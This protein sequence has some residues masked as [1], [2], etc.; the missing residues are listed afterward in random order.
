MSI[1]FDFS[2]LINGLITSF[3]M[4][5][6]SLRFLKINIFKTKISS[7]F[8]LLVL[9]ICIIL[10]YLITNFFIK[11]VIILEILTLII[12]IISKETINKTYIAS[13]FSWFILLISEIFVS[14][15]IT[16]LHLN[17]NNYYGTI[18]IGI[19]ISLIS[20][21]ISCINIID[22]KIY[23][24]IN[25][26]DNSNSKLL[27]LLINAIV[28]SFSIIIY[29]DTI[30]IPKI[31][32]YLLSLLIIIIYTII[33]FRLIEYFNRNIKMQE[34]I[35]LISEN[36][37]EYEKMLDFQRVANH[38]N[39]N[40]L[41]VIKGKLKKKDKDII[42][43]IDEIIKDK[44]DDNDDFYFNTKLIPEGGLQGLIYYKSLTIK[45]KGI[46][47]ILDIDTKI[48]T[49]N[50]KLLS[51]E[52]NSAL[53]K[54]VGVWL[55]NAIQASIQNNEPKIWLEMKLDNNKI[56]LNISNT[57]TGTIDFEKIERTGYT[58]KGKG[59]GYGLTLVHKLIQKY[60]VFE[61]KKSI[62]GNLFRQTLIIE[63]QENSQKK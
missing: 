30:N 59:H 61:N 7:V 1:D 47:L 28:V 27:I 63:K 62:Y 31:V 36:L 33:A 55:D 23:Q 50:F 29:I 46:E 32:L 15:V 20:I 25:K 35:N 42:Q 41:L 43:Y 51:V 57:F 21:L 45:E 11:C 16:L 8:L 18:V 22:E 60:N 9:S 6:S 3:V 53:C 54:I 17:I 2:M 40:S 49:I 10:G 56:I 26:H 44:S 5:F 37:R 52:E 13:F 58:T 48:R 14:I 12:K 4:V 39:K 34:S 38:E 19:I 24:I